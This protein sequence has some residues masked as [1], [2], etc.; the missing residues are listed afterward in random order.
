VFLNTVL[1]TWNRTLGSMMAFAGFV[2]TSISA[3][4]YYTVQIT[5]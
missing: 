4:T 5:S 2:V 1:A 3:L